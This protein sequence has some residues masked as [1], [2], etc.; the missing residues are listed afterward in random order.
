MQR[1]DVTGTG[2]PPGQSSAHAAELEFAATL[3]PLWGLAENTEV[4]V[5]DQQ[6]VNNQT[7]L[8]RHRRDRYVLRVTGFLTIAEVSAEHRILRR[9]AQGYLPFRVPEP[10]AA[11]TGGR[12]SRPRPGPPPCAGGC[13][14]CVPAWAARW[15][16]SA[17]AERSG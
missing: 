12:W 13:L 10:V 8:V 11:A 5:V 14:A 3:L 1:S 6:G 17:S 7:F 2:T 4:S 15:R 16:S 9:L